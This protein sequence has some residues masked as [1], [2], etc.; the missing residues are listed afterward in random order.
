MF[1]GYM[2][3][4]ENF[5]ICRLLEVNRCRRLI[6]FSLISMRGVTSVTLFH[7]HLGR[8]LHHKVSRS[9]WFQLSHT[10]YHWND[11]VAEWLKKA[12]C[13]ESGGVYPRVSES[14]R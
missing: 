3:S 5:T 13:V 9:L 8:A 1:F 7:L 6:W 4:E 12:Q 10:F 11:G 14:R 2:R